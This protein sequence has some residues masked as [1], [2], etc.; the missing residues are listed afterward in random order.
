MAST[1]GTTDAGVTPPRTERMA[2]TERGSGWVSFAGIMLA[3]VGTL[4]FIYGIAAISDSRFYVQDATYILSDLN[5][6]GWLLLCIGI[7]QIGVAC[8]IWA[9]SEWGRWLG[10]ISAGGNAIV[11]LMFISAYPFAAL[12]LFTLDILIIY[13]LVA[14]GG[15]RRTA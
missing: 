14:Y 11:Q 2:E 13:G 15:R 6:Y 9:G 1:F 12:A 10:I 8:A 5:A 7:I 4:N 3:L